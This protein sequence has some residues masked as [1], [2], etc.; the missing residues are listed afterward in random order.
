MRND[1]R[2]DD[3]AAGMEETARHRREALPPEQRAILDALLATEMLRYR[4]QFL[5]ANMA[6]H[7]RGMEMAHKQN[8]PAVAAYMGLIADELA[9]KPANKPNEPLTL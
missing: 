6:A 1:T 4:K 5:P 2:I 7:M 9:K 8:S 3:L